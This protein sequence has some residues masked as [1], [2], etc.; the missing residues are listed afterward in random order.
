MLDVL[1]FLECP[2]QATVEIV[3]PNIGVGHVIATK[4]F[5]PLVSITLLHNQTPERR[6]DFKGTLSEA[7]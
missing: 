1:L 5:K 2:S 4:P 6:G 3:S 7:G